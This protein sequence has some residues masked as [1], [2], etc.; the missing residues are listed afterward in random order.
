M[1]SIVDHKNEP[2]TSGRCIAETSYL[3]R[4][5][6]EALNQEIVGIVGRERRRVEMRCVRNEVGIRSCNQWPNFIGAPF[7]VV[8]VPIL[9]RLKCAVERTK[10]CQAERITCVHRDKKI[11]QL[12]RVPRHR[13]FSAGGHGPAI[14]PLFSARRR[15][16]P[17]PRAPSRRSR[18][19]E[20]GAPACAPACWPS[21]FATAAASW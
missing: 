21:W 11:G 15:S 7:S 14:R 2:F 13:Q 19:C 6:P 1:L 8:H 18:A 20:A 4:L 16:H 3:P 17:R 5:E 9:G 12:D 10:P